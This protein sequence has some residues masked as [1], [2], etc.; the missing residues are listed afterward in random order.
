MSSIGR[1][2]LGVAA[3]GVAALCVTAVPPASAQKTSGMTIGVMA[4]VNY[5]KV[6]QDPEPTDVS[7]D[8]RTGWLVGAFLGV[9]INAMVS[10]EPQVFYSEKGTK[11]SAT[12]GS[13]E[14]EV[15]LG[16]VEVPLLLKLWIPASGNVEPYFF[17]GPEFEYNSSCKVKGS[18]FGITSETDCEGS[19]ADIDIKSTDF[20]ATGGAGIQFLMGRQSVRVDARYTYGLTDINDNPADDTKAKLKGFAVTVGIGFNLN[21]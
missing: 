13:A 2:A 16:Y 14:G 8:Y 21:K 3:L 15:K 17:A 12:Q 4:G 7:Y 9:P 6:T 1:A 19:Q 5:T 18:A 11:I 10:I 20:A